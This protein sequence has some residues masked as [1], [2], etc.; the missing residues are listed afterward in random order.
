MSTTL[1]LKFTVLACAFARFRIPLPADALAAAADRQT[2]RGWYCWS[3]AGCDLPG[4]LCQHLRP[5]D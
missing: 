2:A 4:W 1:M 5:C 3:W